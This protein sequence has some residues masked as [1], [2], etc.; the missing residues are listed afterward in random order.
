MSRHLM[1]KMRRR[2]AHEWAEPVPYSTRHGINGQ[3][4]KPHDWQQARLRR[5][6]GAL[7]AAAPTSGKRPRMT[8]D[9]VINQVREQTGINLKMANTGGNCNVLE[10][11]LEDG[12]WIRAADHDDFCHWDLEHRHDDEGENGPM[13]WDVS[14]HSNEHDE[15]GPWTDPSS[16][17]TIHFPPS[18]TWASGDTEAIHWHQDPDAY[19]HELP[20]VIGDA[21]AS[22]P[23]DAKQR[24]QDGLRESL[25]ESG[26]KPGDEEWRRHF[27]GEGDGGGKGIPDYEDLVNPKQDLDDDFGDIFGKQSMRRT[28]FDWKNEKWDGPMGEAHPDGYHLSKTENGHHLTVYRV[29]RP[30]GF[31]WSIHAPHRESDNPATMTMVDGAGH[32]YG[33]EMPSVEHA[34]AAAEEA[35]KRLYP[36][37]TDTG[38]RE[39]GVDYSDLGKFMEGM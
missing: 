16:G 30:D 38:P 13:G 37:G 4:D 12:S 34:K 17:E 24:Q 6:R 20:R 14:F 1:A 2:A 3:F 21:F 29:R 39:S 25:T 9:D 19:L 7:V 28:A 26:W 5:A 22:M 27:P 15:G 36:I 18:D 35:Y 10:G 23:H 32:R 8:T 31:A 11:R 33:E